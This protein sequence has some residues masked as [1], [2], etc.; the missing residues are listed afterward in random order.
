MLKDD[1]RPY[2]DKLL[3]AYLDD[4]LIFSTTMAEHIR[5]LRQVLDKLREHKRFA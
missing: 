4:I 2:I 1:L 5:D 3:S